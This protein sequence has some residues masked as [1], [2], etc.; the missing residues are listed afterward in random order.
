MIMVNP[1]NFHNHHNFHKTDDQKYI[2]AQDLR[3]IS[4]LW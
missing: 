1:H 2:I 4:L 3:F